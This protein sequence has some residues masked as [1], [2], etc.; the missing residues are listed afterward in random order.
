[1][2]LNYLKETKKEKPELRMKAEG[3]INTGYQRLLTFEVPGGGFSWFGQKP[4][5]KILT[6]WGLLEFNDM[7]SVY[8]IDEKIIERTQ[9]WLVSQQNPDGSFSFD[10]TH[11]GYPAGVNVTVMS[12][13]FI[14]WALAESGYR[15]QATD[16][17]LAYLRSHLD[18]MGDSYTLALTAN[19][20]YLSDS[21][22]RETAEAIRKL[23]SMAVAKEEVACWPCGATV[24]GGYGE[25]GTVEATALAA[26][27]LVRSDSEYELTTRALN[28][29]TSRKSANGSWGSTQATVL[30]LRVLAE[31]RKKPGKQTGTITV[32]INGKSHSTFTIT[33]ENSDVLQMADLRDAV[34]TGENNIELTCADKGSFTWQVAGKYHLPWNKEREAGEKPLSISVSYDRTTLSS[35]D[36]I[37]A[38]AAVT[39]RGTLQG[40]M[41]IVDLGI[42]PGFTVLTGDLEKL[43]NHNVIQRYELTPRKIILYLSEIRAGETLSIPYRLKARFPLRA[44]SPASA[45]Y[46]YYNPAVRAESPPLQLTVR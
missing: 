3:L 20:L 30:A 37:K 40:G 1:M 43:R 10:S 4:A 17:A 6:A 29:L 31:A 19:A 2:I 39:R 13:A 27:A 46:E 25:S 42:P 16:K 5:N 41:V 34:R 22:S 38:K 44:K 28:Y 33:E 45:V 9:R 11:G 14:T 26:Q 35:D 7:N 12:T 15:D 18:T 8:P 23:S 32:S 24:M 21:S 36:I